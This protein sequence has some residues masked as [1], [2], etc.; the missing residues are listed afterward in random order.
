M[1]VLEPVKDA[2]RGLLALVS[3]KADSSRIMDQSGRLRVAWFSEDVRKYRETVGKIGMDI[4]SGFTMVEDIGKDVIK[5]NYLKSQRSAIVL[6]RTPNADYGGTEYLLAAVN[7]C[8]A[9]EMMESHA[10][11]IDKSFQRN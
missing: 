10:D 8:Y 3:E 1:D 7:M 9:L 6:F 4:S 5:D 2:A 11:V